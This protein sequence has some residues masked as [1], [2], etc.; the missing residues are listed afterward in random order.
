MLLNRSIFLILAYFKDH[1][2]HVVAYKK[3]T[4]SDW[5]SQILHFLSYFRN[6]FIY[7]KILLVLYLI[8]QY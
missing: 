1:L 5:K 3:E 7:K 2:F 6:G 4:F 8:T